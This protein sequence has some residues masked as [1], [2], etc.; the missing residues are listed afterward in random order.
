MKVGMS[1]VV[2]REPGVTVREVSPQERGQ[3]FDEAAHYYL[4]MSGEEFARGWD[5]GT[6][7]DN[8]DERKAMRVA[9]LRPVVR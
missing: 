3:I 2:E 4:G 9:L 6:F 8:L 7:D 5:A 1:A